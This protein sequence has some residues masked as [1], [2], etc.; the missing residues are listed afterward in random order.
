MP[1]LTYRKV[2]HHLQ[3]IYDRM[4]NVHGESENLDYMLLFGEIIASIEANGGKMAKLKMAFAD[5][6]YTEGCSCCEDTEAHDEAADQIGEL[7]GFD[8]YSDNSGWDFYKSSPMRAKRDEQRS[9]SE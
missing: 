2:I 8:R 4:H 5:Y 1:N 3:F 7:L 6:A 9:K